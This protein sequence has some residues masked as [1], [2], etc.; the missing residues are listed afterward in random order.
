MDQGLRHT[1]LAGQLKGEGRTRQ[2]LLQHKERG[3]RG[4][5]K[6][7][8]AVDHARF[9]PR[10]IELEVGV[11]GGDDAVGAAGIQL[12]EDGLGYGAA[13]RGF[14]TGTKLVYEDEG[15]GIGHFQHPFHIGEEGAVGGQVVFQ[16]LV[17]SYGDHNAV[18]DRKFG[19]LG[20]GD[21]H[22]PLEH[23]LQQT[24]GLEA[25]ALAAGVGAG[26]E[27]DALLRG[28]RNR[29]GNNGFLLFAEALFQQRVTGLAQ[30]QFSVF[31]EHRHTGN[32][33][34]G[35][36]GLG[37]NEVQLSHKGGA[38]YE[39]RHKG[40]QEFGKLVEDAGNLA[41]FGKVE[42]GNLVLEGHNLGRL[43]EGGFAG[44]AFVVHEALEGTLLGRSHRDEHLSVSDGDAGIGLHYAFLLRLAEDGVHTAGDTQLF[45]FYVAADLVEL[46]GG[47]V[48]DFSV[49]VQDG[50]YAA[51]Y[52]GR[53]ADARS[54]MLEVGIDAFLDRMEEVKGPSERIQEGT[55]LTQ[56][57]E[58]DGSVL[59]YGFQERNGVNI[60]G[61]G[62]ILLK[63]KDEAHLVRDQVPA[64]DLVPVRAEFLLLH[65]GRSILRRAAGHN[66]RPYFVKPQFRFQ[67]LVHRFLLLYSHQGTQQLAEFLH[68]LYCVNLS[69]AHETHVSGFL[70]HY[71]DIGVRVFTQADGGTVPHSV[72]G[73]NVRAVGHRKLATGG[74]NV[75]T[76]DDH[77][78]V[79]QGGVLEENIHNEAPVDI[80]LKTVSGIHILLQGGFVLNHNEGAGLLCR[81]GADGF[82]QLLGAVAAHGFL[83]DAQQ[84]VEQL[85]AAAGQARLN[86]KAVEHMAD[87]GLEQD[88][89]RQHTHIQQGSQ[90]HR[91]HSHIERRDHGFEDEQEHQHQDDVEDGGVSPDTSDEEVNEESDHQ[92][93]QDV[94][95]AETQ[96][97]EYAQH[98]NHNTQRYAKFSI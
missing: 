6:L 83:L 3:Y 47:G 38:G 40:S 92:H 8:S 51:Y 97:V 52:L 29:Q 2:A 88:D 84:A 63:H 80:G 9:G 98:F 67:P 49:A 45:L 78:A 55:E 56:R 31:G 93:V 69:S 68:I 66:G 39:F 28:K 57:Q 17:I 27:E 30:A 77:S 87:F 14:G 32:V 5:V 65:P 15:P 19:G 37:H 71:Q 16:G 86:G 50:V 43:H 81:H 36:I 75:V 1:H 60:A 23:I 13:G 22:P 42:F 34:Q 82:S 4:G 76:L 74:G 53:G 26:D 64:V 11:V 90:Q 35:H 46:V 96:K 33:V 48:L 10:S 89:D 44:G 95:P 54:H 62:E 72:M 79:V 7:H 85:A 59:P 25:H 41:G 20:G 91:H 18:K 73:R 58:V 24:H 94:C 12:V 61:S 70:G 21:E